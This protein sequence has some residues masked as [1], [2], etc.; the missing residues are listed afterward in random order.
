LALSYCLL[1]LGF[2]EAAL[3]AARAEAGEDAVGGNSLKMRKPR[4]VDAGLRS[5]KP[6]L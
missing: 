2:R 5:Q 3:E 6:K 4:V 1:W